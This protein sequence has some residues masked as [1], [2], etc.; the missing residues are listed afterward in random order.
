MT[1]PFTA[2]FA[3][4]Q[5]AYIPYDRDYYHK[6]E[7]YEILQGNTNPFFNT[8]FRPFRRDI[9]AQYLDSLAE[10]PQVIQSKADQ[11]N[12]NYLSQDSWEF[13]KRDLPKSKKPFL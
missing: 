11:F 1:L 7:R 12:L 3:F 4:S 6:I 9:V 5:G 13:S 10:N 8:G 2:Q